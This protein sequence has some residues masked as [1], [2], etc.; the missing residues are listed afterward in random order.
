MKDALTRAVE[1][2]DLPALVAELYPDSKARA[3]QQN[4]VYATWRGNR[5][6]PAFSLFRREKIWLYADKATGETGNAFNFLT[7]IAGV[8]PQEAAHDLMKRAGI[9]PEKAKKGSGKEGKVLESIPVPVEVARKHS[10]APPVKIKPLAGRGFTK[11]DI[12]LFRIIKDEDS[13]D[14]LI[15]ITNPD[16]VI[17]AVKRRI[18]NPTKMK[19]K[20]DTEGHGTPAWCSPN[21]R[22]ANILLV[23]EGELN[24]MVA[25]SV[26]R[27]AGYAFATMG[28]AGADQHPNLSAVEGKTVYI[29]A[30]ADGPGM[31]ARDAWA[32]EV[33]E[34][35][36]RVV[37][38]MNPYPQD[39]CDVAGEHKRSGL[40]EHL[41]ML[42][43]ESVVRYGP[44][45]R[46]VAGY[47][48]MEH[49]E[50][51]KRYISNQVINPT[52]FW[53]LD[54]YTGGAPESG[55]ILWGALSSMGKSAL[56]RRVACQHLMD[57]PDEKIGYFSPD[58]SPQSMF[59]L[60]ATA[61]SGVPLAQVRHNQFSKAVL[62]RFGSP[63]AARKR[64]T[65]IYTWV[66]TE[67]SKRFLLSEESDLA[68]IKE[69][70]PRWID[71]GATCF[72]GDYLQMFEAE[73][74]RGRPIDGKLTKDLKKGVRQWKVPFHFAV[75]LAKYKFPPSRKCALPYP[76][77][78]EGRGAIFHDAEQVYM[79]YNEGI[80]ASKYSSD[81]WEPEGDPHLTGRVTVHKN[82]E[83]DAGK[84]FF[85]PWEPDFV[86]YR[87][88]G[89]TV[90][91]EY[92]GLLD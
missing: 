78:I 72:F 63:E 73:D 9:S 5:D 26:L 88:H 41:R 36:A 79:L 6:T 24:A 8:D 30:D 1:T 12:A 22:G 62:E 49:L 56:L 14:A 13:E 44:L 52:G 11:D 33:H 25:Y 2:I 53:E 43:E 18:H 51:A 3:G 55:L 28:I 64:W 69:M 35:G 86:A 74:E 20:Y 17:V 87:N 39:F 15:P 34:A 50:S 67:L 16:G 70:V 42:I 59:R 31:K 47:T 68:V 75:Q 65:D 82:K 27:E 4:T 40:L 48:V 84:H 57:H 21:T 89:K 45:Q 80:F 66:V 92:R 10:H 71:Q 19:Y 81:A 85:L 60:L 91:D 46:M 77:D 61:I 90:W 7:E 83:G 37:K 29:Y 54:S 58:Q 38:M 32:D 23:V 76:N